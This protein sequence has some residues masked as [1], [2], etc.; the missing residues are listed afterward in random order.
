MTTLPDLF[1]EPLIAGLKHCED[2]IDAAEERALIDELSALDLTP[3]RFHGWLGNRKTKT[4]GWR[5]D[6]DDASFA[7][8][9]PMPEWLLPLRAR[10]AALASV[11]AGR[12]RPRPARALRPGAGIGWHR[13]RPQFEKVVGVSLG[14]P[15]TL[16]FR[17][18]TESGFRRATVDLEAPLRLF[19][20]GRSAPLWEQASSPANSSA[21][22]LLS[23]RCPKRAAALAGEV[24]PRNGLQA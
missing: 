22:L 2:F 16:R 11:P 18:R 7:P 15:A 13:D 21:S 12:V 8:A 17:Q 10:A 3:F 20:L 6:F 19:A 5:Y 9:E 23:G 4:F 1:A 24:T 14:A